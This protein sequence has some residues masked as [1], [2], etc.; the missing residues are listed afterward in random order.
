MSQFWL[1][2]TGLVVAYHWNSEPRNTG[3]SCSSE[4]DGVLYERAATGSI[5]ARGFYSWIRSAQ[6][7]YLL[8]SMNTI[9][10]NIFVHSSV[11]VYDLM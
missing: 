10:E 7:D 4:V 2:N 3:Y 8:F 11:A 9:T 1:N 5:P 6:V